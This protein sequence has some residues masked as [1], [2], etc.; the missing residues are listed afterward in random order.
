[1][2]FTRRILLACAFASVA[3]SDEPGD[4]SASVIAL[5][6]ISQ[7]QTIR[8]DTPFSATVELLGPDGERATAVT[9]AVTLSLVGAGTLTGTTTV[10][11]AQGVATFTNLTVTSAS[12]SLQLRASAAGISATSPSFRATDDCAP[13]TVA[14]PVAVTGSL[15]S[16]SCT[17]D[18]HPAVFYRFTKAELGSV[19]FIVTTD[20]SFTPEI[21]VINDPPSDFIP[22]PPAGTSATGNWILPGAPYRLRLQSLS[23]SAGT[24]TISTSTTPVAGCV[25]RTLLP[26]A[27]VTYPGRV[28]AGDC[29]ENGKIHD[30]YQVYS[31]RP[32]SLTLR[33]AVPAFDALLIVRNIRTHVVL[34]QN[35]NAT[36]TTQDAF[37]MLTECRAGT[38]PI[39]ILATSSNG[40]T[41]DYALTVQITGGVSTFLIGSGGSRR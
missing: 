15:A 22:A 30:W 19:Q 9:D 27:F 28:E 13:A 29:A 31:P 3:C 37:V 40:A 41:G 5:R 11:P 7:P 4:A 14:F 26:F 25:L 34:Q 6:F 36:A 24:F 12:E 39:E 32:C 38:D 2:P 23:G 1:M 33:G 8:I 18:G 10:M 21:T 35:D 20:G 16:S 17:V